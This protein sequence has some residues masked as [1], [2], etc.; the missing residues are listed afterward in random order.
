M[1]LVVEG[2]GH[3][4]GC[5]TILALGLELVLPPL[6]CPSC[7]LAGGWLRQGGA[8]ELGIDG[9]EFLASKQ[10]RLDKRMLENDPIFTGCV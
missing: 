8:V 10:S 7:K 1:A 9:G 5:P 3:D 4:A 6:T 2:K